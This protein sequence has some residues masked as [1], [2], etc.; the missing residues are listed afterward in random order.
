MKQAQPGG[1]SAESAAE[2][3]H[4][5]L[6][7]PDWRRRCRLQVEKRDAPA[8]GPDIA[9][10]VMSALRAVRSRGKGAS[11]GSSQL[12]WAV[13]PRHKARF[14]PR[15]ALA[16]LGTDRGGFEPALVPG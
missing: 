8:D 16:T 7:R 12:K 11:W 4:G 6:H 3:S 2:P 9:T 14:L 5:H 13:A 15:S 10:I 1:K